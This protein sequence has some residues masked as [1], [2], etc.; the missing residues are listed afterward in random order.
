MPT[1]TEVLA[2]EAAALT[3]KTAM[4]A[5]QV[6]VNTSTGLA[7]IL[8][9]TTLNTLTLTYNT[10]QAT[11]NTLRAAYD[12][13]NPVVPVP[14]VVIPPVVVPPIVDPPPPDPPAPEPT[15]SPWR[16][17]ISLGDRPQPVERSR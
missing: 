15:N 6:V 2:A 12:L 17:V 11:A 14:P 9:Q 4:L 10:L 1:L 7:K 16:N 8:A 13:L 3:A 5:Q